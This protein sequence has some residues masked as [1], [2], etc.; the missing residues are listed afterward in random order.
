MTAY[1][2][3]HYYFNTITVANNEA[4][5]IVKN[6]NVMHQSRVSLRYPDAFVCTKS[7]KIKLILKT[8]TKT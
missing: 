6:K 3:L 2:G 4:L 7:L 8:K 1:Q 5:I